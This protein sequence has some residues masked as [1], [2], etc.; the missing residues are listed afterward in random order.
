MSTVSVVSVGLAT[1]L[2]NL[3]IS[4]RLQFEHRKSYLAKDTSMVAAVPRL[5]TR[6]FRV[7]KATSEA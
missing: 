3:N 5:I 4:M 2:L 1:L 6:F 7:E